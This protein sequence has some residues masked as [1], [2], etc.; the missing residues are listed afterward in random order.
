MPEMTL[1]DDR[2]AVTSELPSTAPSS[3]DD[4]RL[5]L[6]VQHFLFEE[7]A[8]MDEHRYDDWLSMWADDLQYWI[9]SDPLDP[10][11]NLRVAL[12]CDDRARLLERIARWKGGHA[13]SQIPRP[14]LV[15]TVSNVRLHGYDD[16]GSLVVTSRFSLMTARP[17]GL[18][19][20]E[21]RLGLWGGTS[22]HHLDVSSGVH[23]IDLRISRKTV[24]LLNAHGPLPN[25]QFLL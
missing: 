11:P 1:T 6:A 19:S 9:P 21:V 14:Q 20:E 8:R 2:T 18:V 5:F 24:R 16:A 10:S 13:H 22:E 15:R 7:A 25:M 23:G 12:V 4:V 3:D 17:T